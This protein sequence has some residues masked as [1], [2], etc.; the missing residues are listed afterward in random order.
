[1]VNL[2]KLFW[3]LLS[4]DSE[5][6]S[7]NQDAEHDAAVLEVNAFQTSAQ[8]QMLLNVCMC[9]FDLLDISASVRQHF[10]TCGQS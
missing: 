7:S 5:E 9:V 8:Y 4:R 6:R 10:R 1:M 3:F 2:Q